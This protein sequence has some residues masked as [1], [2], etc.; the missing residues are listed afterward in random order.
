MYAFEPI[1]DD[2]FENP[3]REAW[4]RS[5]TLPEL[6]LGSARCFRGVPRLELEMNLVQ[7][8]QQPRSVTDNTQ[9]HSH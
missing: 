9:V 6:R 1:P 7:Y 2:G 3:L 5:M 4:H 8:S